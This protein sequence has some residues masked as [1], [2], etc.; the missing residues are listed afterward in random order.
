MMQQSDWR[1]VFAAITTPFRDDGGLDEEF[2]TQHVTWLVEQGC[3][4]LVP[5][6][7]LGEGATLTFAEKVRILEV[8]RAALPGVPVVAGISGLSTMECVALARAAQAAGCDGLMVLPPY[9][10]L[11]DWREIR[12]HFDAVISATSL[13]CMLYN[14]PIAYGT[15]LSTEHVSQLA[16]HENVHAIKDSSGDVRRLTAYRERLGHR[17]ALFAG[18]DDMVFEAA[19]TGADG[20]IAGLVNAMPSESVL[21]FELASAGRIDEARELYNWFLPLLRLDTVPKFVQLIK[22]V[23]SVVGKGSERVRA[24]RLELEGGER[25]EALRI[26]RKQLD[27]RQVAGRG[28]AGT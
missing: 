25:E 20:W 12:A 8:C 18:L 26:I 6:G 10:Y 11:G 7:S 24:P 21:L 2:L 9:V 23:Q 22:L 13:S 16:Q 15:D 5:L 28:T 1:G 27:Q 14:N 3:R 17:L 19:A 4:G